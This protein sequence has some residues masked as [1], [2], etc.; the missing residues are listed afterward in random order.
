M[1]ICV[2]K[3]PMSITDDPKMPVLPETYSFHITDI[4][5]NFGAGFIVV[6]SGDILDMPGLPIVPRAEEMDIES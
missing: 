1:P 6:K 4:D 2:S 3:T 5:V